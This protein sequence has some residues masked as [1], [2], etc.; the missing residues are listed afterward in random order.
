M[1]LINSNNTYNNT[2]INLNQNGSNIQINAYNTTPSGPSLTITTP[3]PPQGYS[4]QPLNEAKTKG[5][6]C[7]GCDTHINFNQIL[8]TNCNIRNGHRGYIKDPTPLYPPQTQSMNETP[9]Q[10]IRCDTPP[11]PLGHVI[12]E[13]THAQKYGKQCWC[14]QTLMNYQ[15]TTCPSCHRSNGHRGYILSTKQSDCIINNDN[16]NYDFQCMFFQL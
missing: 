2:T 3:P 11:P 12:Q 13:L 6:I 5:K 9:Q 10:P 8:C 15:T 14:C 1:D 16:N 7:I 4:I